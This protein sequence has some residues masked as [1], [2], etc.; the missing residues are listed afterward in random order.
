MLPDEVICLTAQVDEQLE[1]A[2]GTLAAVDDIGHV[3]GQDEGRPV[4]VVGGSAEV[5]TGEGHAPVQAS[6]APPCSKL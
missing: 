5:T 6:T 4:S 2:G 3:R 1:A